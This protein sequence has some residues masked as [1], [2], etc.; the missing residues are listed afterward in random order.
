[1]IIFLSTS[2]PNTNVVYPSYFNT[3]GTI[4]RL[5]E[6]IWFLTNGE[7]KSS[8]YKLFS[9]SEIDNFNI[10][11]CIK[12]NVLPY[13]TSILSHLLTFTPTLNRYLLSATDVASIS[14]DAFYWV[15]TAKN[16]SLKLTPLRDVSRARRQ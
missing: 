11:L 12:L 4:E 8:L 9:W 1:M 7:T 14:G 3:F 15:S 16:T 2:F 13:H 10:L 5:A 6:I